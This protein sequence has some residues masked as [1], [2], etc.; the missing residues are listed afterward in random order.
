[1]INQT[2]ALSGRYTQQYCLQL[3]FRKFLEALCNCTETLPNYPIQYEICPKFIDSIYNCEYFVR[4]LFIDSLDDKQCQVDCPKECE[5]ISFSTAVSNSDFP[6]KGYHS[7]LNKKLGTVEKEGI[8]SLN[9]YYKSSG[10]IHIEEVEAYTTSNFI[11][12]LGGCLSQF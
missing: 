10:Y 6:S 3:C 9:V 11:S 12:D 1:M 5:F 8:V 2:I 4:R 7:I